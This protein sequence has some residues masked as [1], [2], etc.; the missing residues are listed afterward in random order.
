METRFRR[1][2]KCDLPYRNLGCLHLL[3][4]CLDLA[5]LFYVLVQRSARNLDGLAVAQCFLRD[6]PP[7]PATPVV[8][9]RTDNGSR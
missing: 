9:M 5:T 1:T 4:A 8:W 2:T 3:C 6:K 7:D